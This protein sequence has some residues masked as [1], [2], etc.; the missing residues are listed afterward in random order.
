MQKACDMNP[1]SS[2]ET[3]YAQLTW[4]FVKETSLFSILSGACS[5]YLFPNLLTVPRIKNC[6]ALGGG[7]ALASKLYSSFIPGPSH[8]SE[9]KSMLVCALLTFSVCTFNTSYLLFEERRILDV[10][11]SYYDP[12][13]HGGNIDLST[14]EAKLRFM[15]LAN[16]ILAFIIPFGVFFCCRTSSRILEKNDGS[17]ISQEM[18]K[19]IGILEQNSKEKEILL[20]LLSTTCDQSLQKKTLDTFERFFTLIKQPTSSQNQEK[21]LAN[22]SRSIETKQIEK[23][24]EKEEKTSKQS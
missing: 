11:G 16:L 13:V 18:G 19:L 17:P 5:F 2:S 8:F 15:N 9:Y 24:E 3:S 23:K 21:K 20:K 22:E 10:F 6:T 1:V 12:K 7:L 14:N 4:N